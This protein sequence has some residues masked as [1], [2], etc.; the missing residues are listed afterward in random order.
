MTC[1]HQFW[2][3]LGKK[4]VAAT[5]KIDVTKFYQRNIDKVYD[6][7]SIFKIEIL[8]MK[9]WYISITTGNQ[10]QITLLFGTIFGTMNPPEYTLKKR[11]NTR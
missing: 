6:N 4:N 7:T 5:D 9:A 8:K 1:S 2:V 3:L 10:E 11:H